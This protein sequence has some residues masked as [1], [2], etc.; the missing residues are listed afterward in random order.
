MVT[1]FIFKHWN[2]KSNKIKCFKFQQWKPKFSMP[3][4][5]LTLT[6]I[7]LCIS[8]HFDKFSWFTYTRKQYLHYVQSIPRDLFSH[9]FP[10]YHPKAVNVRPDVIKKQQ[11]Q[12]TKVGFWQEHKKERAQLRAQSRHT[13]HLRARYEELLVPSTGATDQKKA[14]RINQQRYFDSVAVKI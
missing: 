1:W 13:S 12:I 8:V 7:S 6:I 3:F 9:K 14:S 10:H 2:D 5:S 4:H 11:S